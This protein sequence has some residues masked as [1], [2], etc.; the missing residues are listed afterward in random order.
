MARGTLKTVVRAPA[1]AQDGGRSGTL[2]FVDNSVQ[3][4]VGHGGAARH[5]AQ[6]RSSFL[7][8]AIR[9]GAPDSVD[10]E[11]CGADSQPG[12]ADQPARP[13]RIRDQAGQHRRFAA[14]DAGAAPGRRCCGHQGHSC[15]RARG[16][17]GAV[18]RWFPARRC[19]CR[20][21][22][23]GRAGR[24]IARSAISLQAASR[25]SLRTIHS[26]S[27]NDGGVDRHPPSFLACW[28][29]CQSAGERPAGGGLSGD[30]GVRELSGRDAGNDGQQRRHAARAAVHADSRA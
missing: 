21:T 22:R 28:P 2:T 25:E 17:D 18:D 5:S 1:D 13:L 16:G 12:H 15:R 7:A 24:T 20:K 23:R 4:G 3:N 29:I 19:G 27:G 9:N 10:A 11:K 14:G 6:C 30:P 26:P 8:G